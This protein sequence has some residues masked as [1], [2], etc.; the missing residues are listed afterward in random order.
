[1][2]QLHQALGGTGGAQQVAIDLA[3]HR[4]RARQDD[5][6]HHGLAQVSGADPAGQHRLRALV[7]A[8]QQRGGRWR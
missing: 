3:Q 4:H 2:Q 8:P 6:V 7:Q 5:H 1:V